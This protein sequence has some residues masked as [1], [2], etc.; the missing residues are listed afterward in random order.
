[1]TSH[2]AEKSFGRDSR[3]IVIDEFCGYLVCV[4]FIPK[5]I[6][7]LL[8]GFFLF[9]FF[10]VVKPPP[11]RKIEGALKGGISIMLDDLI[12]GVYTNTCIQLWRYLV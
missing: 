7:Y 12:A 9:R 11:I 8:A 1:L 3:H 5:H 4:L 6:T 10:D 2:N